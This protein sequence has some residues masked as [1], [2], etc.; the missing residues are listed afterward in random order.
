MN[1]NNSS[2]VSAWTV[3]DPITVLCYIGVNPIREKKNGVT[4]EH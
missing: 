3:E 2:G 1:M 4:V